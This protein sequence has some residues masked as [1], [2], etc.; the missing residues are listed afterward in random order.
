MQF[1]DATIQNLAAEMFWRMAEDVGV[2]ETNERVISS[3]GWCLHKHRFDNQL[4]REYPLT[5]LSREEADRVLAAVA[6]EA[7]DVTRDEQNMIGPVYLEDRASGRSPSAAS[8]DT[9]PLA[10]VPTFTSDRPIERIGS[11]CLRHP[12]PAVVFADRMPTATVVQVDDTA[13][14]LGFDLPLF[15]VVVG[16]QRADDTTLILTGYFQIPVPDVAIGDLWSHVIQNSTRTVE[17]TTLV[18]CE[19]GLAIRYQWDAGPKKGW[20]WFRRP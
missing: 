15:L 13:T 6:A 10:N 17:G 4:W 16:C 5:S 19:D 2:A 3:E 11:L 1:D 12:L 7:Y 9:A 8:I 20:S 14:A 18:G